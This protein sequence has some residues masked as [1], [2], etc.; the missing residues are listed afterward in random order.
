MTNL[1]IAT[2][3][4]INGIEF[5]ISSDGTMSGCSVSGIARMCGVTQGSITQLLSKITDISKT[6]P[7]SLESLRGKDLTLLVTTNNGAKV[8]NSEVVSVIIAHYA[9]NPK[10]NNA[11][12]KTFL[13]KFAAKGLHDFIKKV[14]GYKH[15]AQQPKLNMLELAKAYIAAEEKIAVLKPK[16]DAYD[17][18]E[19]IV[20]N[21]SGLS[22]IIKSEVQEEREPFTLNEYLN[23]RGIELDKGTMVKFSRAVAD[24]Y[25]IHTG[26]YPTNTTKV[27]YQKGMKRYG[28]VNVYEAKDVAMIREAM[29]LFNII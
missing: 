2:S 6:L 15:E 26:L 10:T 13:T 1:Q 20:S 7:E 5:Y 29:K 18:I 27:Y 17:K 16:A 9:L 28:T 25:K 19:Q 23:E 11:T 24:T 22:N 8:I 12:A 3:K 14:T 21:Q 4:V